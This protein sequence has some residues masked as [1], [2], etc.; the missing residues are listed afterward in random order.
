MSVDYYL[1]SAEKKVW[2]P[3][4]TM[5]VG[6]CWQPDKRY[7][8]DFLLAAGSD[9]KL[10][11]EEHAGLPEQQDDKEWTFINSYH[12]YPEQLAALVADISS[13]P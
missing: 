8:F 1:V 9:V 13:K 7:V 11:Q 6:G 4:F 10:I 12:P 3:I 2:M 5:T